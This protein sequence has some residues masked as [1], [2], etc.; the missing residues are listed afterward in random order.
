MGS[1]FDDIP[2]RLPEERFDTLCR[3][4]HIMIERIISRGHASPPGFWYDQEN[5]EFVLVVKGR[6][7]LKI[8]NQPD[9]LIL[10]AGDYT[11]IGAHVKHRVEWTD[12]DGDTLWL[13]IHF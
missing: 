9:I 2:K 12:P 6:A 8:E 13:A 4:D 10:N 1:F 5:E 3:T 7:G 11:R